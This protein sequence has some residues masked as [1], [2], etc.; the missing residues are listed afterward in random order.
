M[1]ISAVWTLG[2]NNDRY[3]I[4]FDRPFALIINLLFGLPI[5]C[6]LFFATFWYYMFMI[7][8]DKMLLMLPPVVTL[9]GPDTEEKETKEGVEEEVLIP[10]DTTE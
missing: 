4:T 10:Q 6:L 5:V 7:P 8:L 2:I 1:S 9:V 3:K